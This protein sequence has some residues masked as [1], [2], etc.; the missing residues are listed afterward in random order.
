MW[1]MPLKLKKKK[2][3]PHYAVNI[4]RK[5]DVIILLYTKIILV[6]IGIIIL[7]YCSLNYYAPSVN[8]VT[9]L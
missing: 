3:S 9:I 5:T 6:F 8:N 4:F 2:K 7:H 1:R